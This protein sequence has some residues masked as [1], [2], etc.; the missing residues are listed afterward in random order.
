DFD[1]DGDYDL[2]TN[3][4]NQTIS[5]LKNNQNDN[6]N[7]NFIKLKLVGSE[8]NTQGIGAKI[9]LEMEDKTIF[10]EAFNARGYL[11]S[12]EPI[13]SIGIGNSTRIKS[14]KVLWPGGRQLLLNDIE[15]NQLIELV[16]AQSQLGND[17]HS[18]VPNK[19]ALVDVTH[20]SGIKFRHV[21]S[22]FVDF[23]KDKL[24]HYQLSN[25]GGR[26]ASG[27][28]NGDGNDDIYFG[29][30][31]GQAA[32][33]YFGTNDGT[34]IMSK[35]QPWVVDSDME[36]MK[37]LFFDADGDGD[38]DLYVVSGGSTFY[39]NS[40]QYQDRYYQNIGKGQF[41]KLS[42]AL[43]LETTSGSCAIS[44]DFDKDGDLDLFVGGRHQGLRYPISPSSFILRNE[45]EG[46]N[47]KFVNAT[48]EIC[49]SLEHIGMVTDAQ[50]TDYNGDGWLDLI[51]VGEWMEIKVFQNENGKLIEQKFTSLE[52][53]NGWWT[54][55]RQLDIDADGDLDYLLGNAGLNYR[56]KASKTEPVEL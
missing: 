34:F 2:I 1:N 52:K 17:T 18:A 37:P 30:A 35:S 21:A 3:N 8:S 44:G 40:P 55:I 5:I 51:V 56:I 20:A 41:S 27:D 39:L 46:A 53:S 6:L 50:W 14:L 45:S 23:E 54:T 32:E 15:A 12:S 49:A 22:D 36:D 4:L 13:I 28:V 33:L 11:S 26:L 25:L 38:L 47:V 24:L 9:W 7:N 43:P 48:S 10:H 42:S 19:T 31:A 16:Y 29:G